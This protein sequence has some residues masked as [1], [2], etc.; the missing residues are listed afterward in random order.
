MEF[1]TVR[2]RYH[3]KIRFD[4]ERWSLT[5]EKLGLIGLALR[6]DPYLGHATAAGAYDF[7]WRDWR[8]DEVYLVTYARVVTLE[9]TEVQV[10]RVKRLKAVP[11][12]MQVVISSAEELSQRLKDAGW[13]EL[14]AILRGI[15]RGE[16][17]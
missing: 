3:Q 17:E 15:L 2:L 9:V 10:I 16:D 8:R 7:A 11:K 12:G 1:V 14:I 5:E 6:D 13:T 4:A